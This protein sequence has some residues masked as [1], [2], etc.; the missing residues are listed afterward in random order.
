MGF[1]KF[2]VKAAV[3]F[4]TKIYVIHFISWNWQVLFEEFVEHFLNSGE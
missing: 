2:I 3:V 4:S 1:C